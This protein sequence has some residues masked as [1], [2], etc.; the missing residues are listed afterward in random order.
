MSPFWEST[1]AKV[2]PSTL[3]SPKGPPMTMVIRA[4]PPCMS[5]NEHKAR[6][7]GRQCLRWCGQEASIRKLGCGLQD[8]TARLYQKGHNGGSE[9]DTLDVWSQRLVYAAQGLEGVQASAARLLLCDCQLPRV[10]ERACK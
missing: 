9:F 7:L 3:T 6:A 2:K 8:A 10:A 4:C 5:K 1:I